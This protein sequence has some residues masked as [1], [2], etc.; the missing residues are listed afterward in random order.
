MDAAGL[1]VLRFTSAE[2]LGEPER[3][4]RELSAAIARRSGGAPRTS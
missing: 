4:A 1:D 3:M 2:V